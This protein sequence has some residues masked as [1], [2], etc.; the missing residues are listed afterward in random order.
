MDR[1][2]IIRAPDGA[3][4]AILHLREMNSPSWMPSKADF[5]IPAS[6]LSL[7]GPG[8]QTKGRFFTDRYV[9]SADGCY[10]LIEEMDFD[11]SQDSVDRNSSRLV[12]IDTRN[13]A[14]A[15]VSRIADGS[16]I[17]KRIE[18]GLLVYSKRRRTEN[19]FFHEFERE[20]DGLTWNQ[21]GEVGAQ[22]P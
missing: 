7:L 9:T 13:G 8:T 14:E 15:E 6:D 18:S 16:C 22:N 3:G 5:W 2:T 12:L 19:G 17:P 1:D 10:L 21:P 20:L 4:V 11:G